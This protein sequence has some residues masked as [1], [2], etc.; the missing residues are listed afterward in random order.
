LAVSALLRARA[1]GARQ[2]LADAPLIF[3]AALIGEDSCIRLYGLYAY[4]P[5]W[6]FVLDQVPLLIPIIW[7]FVVLSARDVAQLLGGPLAPVGFALIWFDAS[8]IE[9]C[10]TSS[11]LWTW[12]EPGPFGVPLIGTLGWACFGAS[13]LFWL[14]RLRG[15]ARWLAIVLGPLTMHALL[16]LLWWGA[17]RWVG[18]S[19][20]QPEWIAGVAWLVTV[21]LAAV[22]FASGRGQRVSLPL[23][24]PR[25]GPAAFFFALLATHAAGV[26]L[27]AYAAAFSLP[28]LI[29]TQW[30]APSR[31]DA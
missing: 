15:P 6:H 31:A 18:R 24:L 29:A 17:L 8:L 1:P 21:L 7:I 23:I 13:M 3:L 19:A 9:P 28:W 2:W 10:A 14:D 16:L 26:A 4:A 12:S 30:R 5:G 20:P 27:W 11:G 25:L 22:L